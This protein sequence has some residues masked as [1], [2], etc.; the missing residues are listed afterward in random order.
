MKFTLKKQPSDQVKVWCS[1]Y[2]DQNDLCQVVYLKKI[3]SQPRDKRKSCLI[4]VDILLL[5]FVL[6]T[7][8]WIYIKII[9]L[10]VVLFAF[11]TKKGLNIVTFLVLDC[12]NIAS[13]EK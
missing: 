7:L 2:F 9:R 1:K 3:S 12:V 11:C 4:F 10:F 6:K 13:I 8:S 5:L